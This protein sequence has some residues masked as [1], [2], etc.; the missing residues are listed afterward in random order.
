MS[1]PYDAERWYEIVDSSMIRG[2][3]SRGKDLVVEFHSG[4]CYAYPGLAEE[5]DSLLAADSVGKYFH[6]HVRHQPSVKLGL[7]WYDE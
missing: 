1:N 2:V 6:Q 4:E 5:V 3:G 7:E